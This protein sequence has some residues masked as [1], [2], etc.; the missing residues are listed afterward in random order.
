MTNPK[1]VARMRHLITRLGAY[2]ELDIW[3]NFK[4]K[5]FEVYKRPTTN[6]DALEHLPQDQYVEDYYRNCRAQGNHILKA[7]RLTFEEIERKKHGQA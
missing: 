2:P 1:Q 5:K 4:D 3:Y 7:M 6:R